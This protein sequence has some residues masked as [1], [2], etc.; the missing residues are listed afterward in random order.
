MLFGFTMQLM[1]INMRNSAR[2][3]MSKSIIPIA[4]LNN[5]GA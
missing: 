2:K 3:N 4:E 5:N 1:M